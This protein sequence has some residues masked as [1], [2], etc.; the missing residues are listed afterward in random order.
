LKCSQMTNM[1]SR[2]IINPTEDL[3]KRKMHGKPSNKK[4]G[5]NVSYRPRVTWDFDPTERI[6]P[7]KKHEPAKRKKFNVRDLDDIIEE[8]ENE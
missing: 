5:N 7:S 2:K 4:K 6:K 8:E 1:H 3:T